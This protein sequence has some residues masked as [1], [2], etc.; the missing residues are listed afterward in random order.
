MA[1]SSTLSN[2]DSDSEKEVLMRPRRHL[3][4]G[5][6]P[7]EESDEEVSIIRR[8]K[9]ARL[10][11]P[12]PFA[13]HTRVRAPRAKRVR[14][15]A[16][17]DEEESDHDFI[18]VTMVRASR[19]RR[20]RGYTGREEDESDSDGG[21]VDCYC[22]GGEID[23]YCDGGE[24]DCYCDRSDE[25]GDRY[26][27]RSEE[28]DRYHDRSEEEDR[29]RDRSEEED[30]YSEEEREGDKIEV[31]DEE[32]NNERSDKTILTLTDPDLFECPICY[33]PLTI[34]V[35]QCNQN[36]HIACSSCI[37]KINNKC[38]SCSGSICSN[39]CRAIEKILKSVSTISCRNAKHGCKESVTYDKRS[40][41][42]KT[43]VYSPC[44]CPHLGCDF[45]ASSKQICQHFRRKHF[46]SAKRFEYHCSFPVT[47]S[48]TDK[49]VVFQEKNE[50]AL[51]VLKNHCVK[52][53]GNAVTLSCIQPSSTGGFFYDLV[54]KT[55]G[56]RLRLQAFT[57][58]TPRIIIDDSP[59]KTGF[60]L[61]PTDY[62]SSCGQLK[63]DLRIWPEDD[64][65]IS[66]L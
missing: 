41:H 60:H 39:R 30:R 24:V 63:M 19:A 47:L 66:I 55:K 45:V 9:R 61:I 23:C 50:G 21:E 22:D 34:P 62:I 64:H 18:P 6:L 40:E 5:F 4:P 14:G 52:D 51:F 16:E 57:K 49:F 15:D 59:P 25:E 27:D 42:Q 53:L 13:P 17:R 35:F 33:E 48:A 58:S 65:P 1:R 43:C 54:V 29:Y 12:N 2:G 8:T 26:R 38:P 56:N 3:K 32:E 46:G 31:E 20:G 11:R 10:S 37:G 36:G 28:G 7:S 44:S